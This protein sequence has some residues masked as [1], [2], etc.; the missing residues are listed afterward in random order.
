LSNVTSSSVLETDDDD[1]ELLR[2]KL[3]A[4]VSMVLL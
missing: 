3:L 4:Q 2:L 1:T